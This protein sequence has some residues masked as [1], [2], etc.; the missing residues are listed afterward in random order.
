MLSTAKFLDDVSEEF[1]SINLLTCFRMAKLDA[2][3]EGHTYRDIN[4]RFRSE[5]DKL[6]AMAPGVYEYVQ[7]LA[8]AEEAAK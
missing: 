3:K 1:P 4:A 8:K 6:R 5:Q 2:K 7:A